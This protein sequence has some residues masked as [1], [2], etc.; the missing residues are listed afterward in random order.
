MGNSL[1]FIENLKVFLENSRRPL[2]Y[3]KSMPKSTKFIHPNPSSLSPAPVPT[4]GKQAL[5]RGKGNRLDI[6]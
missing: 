3:F 2:I 6:N 5:G 1:Y 4:E